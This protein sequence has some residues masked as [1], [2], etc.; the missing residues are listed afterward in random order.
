MNAKKILVPT[1]FSEMS[2]AAVDYAAALAREGGGE[3]LIVTVREITPIY[4][5]AEGMYCGVEEP[6]HAAL[7]QM[8][9]EVRPKD[10]LV[11]VRREV[12]D[13][14]PADAIVAL[15]A[16]EQVDLIVMATHGRTGLMHLLMGS[17][18]EGV[19]RNADCPVLTLKPAVKSAAA[20]GA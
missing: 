8:L 16:A 18:A 4:A 6:N 5:T 17:V 13:G 3:L 10:P 20:T 7:K 9:N 14:A 15:A 19:V 1:D 11:R 12:L 2:R